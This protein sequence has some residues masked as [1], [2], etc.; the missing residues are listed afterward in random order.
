VSDKKWTRDQFD[1]LLSDG[2]ELLGVVVN[3]ADRIRWAKYSAERAET[4]ATAQPVATAG[5]LWCALRRLE[6]ISDDLAWHRFWPQLADWEKVDAQPVDP[7]VEE[8]GSA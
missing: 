3:Y 6:L 2:T 5:V 4:A 8:A 1:V 7:T